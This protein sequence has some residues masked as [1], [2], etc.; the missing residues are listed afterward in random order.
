MPWSISWNGLWWPRHFFTLGSWFSSIVDSMLVKSM[1][2]SLRGAYALIGHN[3]AFT[4]APS[5]ILQCWQ[6]LTEVQQSSTIFGHQKHSSA[7]TNVLCWPWCLAFWC[8]P[9]RAV[10][11]YAE[12]TTN[13][14]NPSVPPLG[15]MFTYNNPLLMVKL[16]L[17]Q[18]SALPSSEFKGSPMHVLS[19]A[20]LLCGV[21]FFFCTHPLMAGSQQNVLML[22][23]LPISHVHR[24]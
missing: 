18:N 11:P 19:R 20:S 1:W 21:T 23:L 24:W 8:T 10:H 13:A 12:G 15:M 5:N 6:P 2:T 9:F 3:G 14:S 22:C 7:S 16:F 4:T 17:T